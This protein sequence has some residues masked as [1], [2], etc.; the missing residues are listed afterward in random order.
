[1]EIQDSEKPLQQAPHRVRCSHDKRNLGRRNRV[2]LSSKMAMQRQ[3]LSSLLWTIEVVLGLL[4]SAVLLLISMPS[5]LLLLTVLPRI[6]QDHG[7]ALRSFL[8]ITAMFLGG[9]LGLTAIAM[10]CSPNRLRRSPRL[11]LL[12][13]LFACAGVAAETVCIAEEGFRVTGSNLF[14]VWVLLGPLIIGLHCLYRIFH[15][16]ADTKEP[17]SGLVAR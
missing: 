2:G 9:I 13:L 6:V 10:A 3:R 8:S 11:R 17:R 5:Y 1:M 12:A 7:A 15:V 4:P 16:E 14:M